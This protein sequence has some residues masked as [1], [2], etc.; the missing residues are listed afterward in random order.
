MQWF[1]T[2][3]RRAGREAPIVTEYRIEPNT[4]RCA[5]TGHE[6]KPGERFFTALT[7]AEGQFV[8]RD[9]SAE[10]WAGC[11]EG[12]IIFWAG[13]VPLQEGP[14]RLAIDD[15]L[16]LD[17]FERLDGQTEPGRLNFRYVVALLLM[18]RKKLKFDSARVEGGR[19]TLTLRAANSDATYEVVNPGLTDEAMTAVQDEVFRLLGWQ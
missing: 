19:E 4:R 10:A 11:P 15:D 7:E 6:L 16:L 8:R 18:R 17:C 1:K 12:A 9:Y 13:R 2:G 3:G 5:V 14:Q